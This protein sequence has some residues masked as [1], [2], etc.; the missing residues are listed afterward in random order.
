MQALCG[1]YASLY[2]K[3]SPPR[4]VHF[5]PAFQIELCERPGSPLFSVEPYISGDYVKHNNNYG[6]VEEDSRNTPQA[7]SHFTFEASDRKLLVVDIQGVRDVY[8]DPQVHSVDGR[9]FGEGN[10]GEEGFQRFIESHRCNPICRYLKLTQSKHHMKSIVGE[11]G[12]VPNRRVMK[13]WKVS[14]CM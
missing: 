5:I 1:H 12:T 6:D 4:L 10:L 13:E 2:N 3:Y 14:G 11:D 9:G 7:F 8:T